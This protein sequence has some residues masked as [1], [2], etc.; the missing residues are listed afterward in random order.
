MSLIIDVRA[1]INNALGV[2]SVTSTA[3]TGNTVRETTGK[4]KMQIQDTSL[5]GKIIIE[6]KDISYGY[7]DLAIVNHF[8]TTIMR[9]DKV[10][11]VG[12]NGV[13]KTTLLKIR[14]L[15]LTKLKNLQKQT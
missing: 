11:L 4:A 12:P 7:Q 8:S 6:A 13:G 5:S 2:V 3:A 9:G 15:C 14:Q 10:G 1:V